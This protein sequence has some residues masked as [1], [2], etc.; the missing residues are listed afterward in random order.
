MFGR[1][2]KRTRRTLEE[3]TLR[4]FLHRSAVVRWIIALGATGAL[5][6]LALVGGR[7]EPL[8]LTVGQ[9]SLRTLVARVSFSFL[10][11]AATVSERNRHADQTP[12]VHRLALDLFSRDFVRTRHLLERVNALKQ[13]GRVN[14]AGLKQ[15]AEIWNESA[16]IPL[17]PGDVQS[18]LYLPD[19][20]G[21]LVTL[22]RAGK[23][24]A[25]A[26]IGSDDQFR[27]DPDATAAY[28]PTPEDF[29]SLRRARAG[30]FATSTQARQ[31]LMERLTESVSIPRA[32]RPTVEKL[33][34]DLMTPNLQLDLTLSARLRERQKKEIKPVYKTVTKGAVLLERGERVTEEKLAMLKAHDQE[35][36]REDSARTRWRQRTGTVAILVVIVGSAVLALAFPGGRER[37]TTNREYGLLA[38]IV[39]FHMAMCRLTLLAA[40][41]TTGLS[42]SLIPAL[43]PA[44]LGPMLCAV[45]SHRRLANAVAYVTSFLLGVIT[46]FNF[47]VML[48]ALI[49]SVVGI[50]FLTPVRRRARIYEA[51]AFAGVASAGVNLVFGFMSEV[52]WPVIGQQ[53]ALALGCT[54]AVSVLVIAL[55]PIFEMLFK[56]TTDLRW[57]ELADLNHPLLRRMVMEA[58]GTYHHSLLVANL[59][60]RAC[61]AIGAN[62]LMARV[63]SY[64]H[65]IGKLK[66]PEY[67][68][69]NQPEGHNPHEDIAP[70]MSALIIIAHVKDGVD[71]A[72][73]HRMVRP[74]I[75]T[76]RQHHG[77]TQVSY[78]YR[79]AKRHEEEARL[80]S[81]IMRMNE[82]DVPRVEEETYRYPGPKPSTREIAVISL[83]D[84]IEAAARA[85]P[86]PTPQKIEA[87]VQEAIAQ[88]L[89][90][91]QLDKCDLT[92]REMRVVAASFVKTLLGMLHARVVYPKDDANVDQ[93]SPLS[94]PADS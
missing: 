50:H 68:C 90:D 82:S 69:E 1:S 47:A 32:T 51:G 70:N 53:S 31:K 74:V 2:E 54:L 39:V 25:D 94:S 73:Q 78:F 37:A 92:L 27:G 62:A 65:D 49:S 38:T 58:P 59:A 41:F 11:E 81:R 10:D 77:T 9:V 40:D 15:I 3:R 87:L 8:D 19:R 18:L 30:T 29:A 85:M 52:P 23:R 91:T 71:L 48:A 76:I 72:L 5:V 46:H 60:E 13:A 24:L 84:T 56:V 42:P 16:D 36:K 55:L 26:G 21:F 83:A 75:D 67:F 7:L 28:S 79:L 88:R 14:E 33:I 44:C 45:L 20:P 66:N 43:L 12:N 34:A 6:F 86:R 35:S 89:D 61:E 93:P 4:N 64:F 63:C 80:G 22:E 17:G 57:L